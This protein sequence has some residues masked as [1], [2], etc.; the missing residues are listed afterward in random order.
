MKKQIQLAANKECANGHGIMQSLKLPA[1][2]FVGADAAPY[3]NDLYDLCAD[4]VEIPWARL[5]VRICL[6]CGY[7]ESIDLTQ[8]E[9]EEYCNPGWVIEF[10]EGIPV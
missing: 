1:L 7:F 5:I 3:L 8:D 10:K 2:V 9:F 6:E 4:E